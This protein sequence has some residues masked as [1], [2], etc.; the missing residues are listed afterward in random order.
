MKK[1]RTKNEAMS[2]NNPTQFHTQADA[3]TRK[4]YATHTPTLVLWFVVVD[5]DRTRKIFTC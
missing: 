3:D 2:L 5:S 1:N 4:N